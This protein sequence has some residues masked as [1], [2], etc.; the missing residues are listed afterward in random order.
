M[1]IKQTREEF[2]GRGD[3][4]EFFNKW[5]SDPNTPS[6]IYIHDALEEN[7]KHAEGQSSGE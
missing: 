6:V 7:E 2:I 1:S 4:I 5:L 3:D